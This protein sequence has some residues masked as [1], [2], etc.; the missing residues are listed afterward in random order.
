MTILIKDTTILK[1]GKEDIITG[2]IA[3]EDNIIKY[4]GKIPDNFISDTVIDGSNFIAM[5]G[6]VNSHTHSPMAILRNL[7]DDLPFNDWL[8]NKIIPV[9]NKLTED[10]IYWGSLL[11]IMEMIKSGTT[12][13]ADMYLHMDSIIKAV[14]ASGIR[15]NLS[16]GFINSSIRE[17][18]ATIDPKNFE[19]LINKLKY[20]PTIIPS[21]E[22]HSVYLLDRYSLMEISSLAK[23]LD[24]G[25]HIHLC[26][27]ESELSFSYEKYGCS[28]IQAT[29]NLQ[30]LD[31][32]V[33]AAHCV[34]IKENDIK[35]LKEKNINIAHCPSSNLKL[36]NGIA[37]IKRLLDEGLNVCLGT[38]GSASNNNLNMFEE[39]H[40]TALIHKGIN[41]DPTCVPATTVINM[42]SINGANALGF[43]D[44]GKITPGYKADIILIN[45]K[46]QPHLHP[47]N[48]I[49]SS[50]VYSIQS[51]DVDTV[52]VD[53]QI[54][55]QNRSFTLLDE[56]RIFYKVK[57][58][59]KKTKTL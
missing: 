46:D 35:I 9:E 38:D 52:I 49:H 28:P 32:P 7:A 56:E 17:N 5:P 55:M 36:G 37:P 27:S 34:K 10:D 26:E 16:L 43:K 47:I 58:I 48:N 39:M 19:T 21:M 57:E 33:I 8:F 30:I 3:I 18:N 11:G 51:S 31:L 45:I 40:I 44:V 14:C 24:I 22:A 41:Q 29:Y 2:S 4:V 6:L 25:I 13:F 15:A 1:S 20:H 42:A 53:G 54:L 50:I 12:C 59:F 23:S